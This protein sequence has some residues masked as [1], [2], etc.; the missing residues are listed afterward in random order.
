[1]SKEHQDVI[2][3][4][5]GLGGL[6]CATI[7][8]REGR[9]VLLLEK[10]NQL[11]GNLQTFSRDKCIFDTGVHYI[12]SLGK[13]QN[14]HRYFTYLG[15]M[16]A[17]KIEQMDP[18]AFDHISFDDDPKTYF[19]SQ[20]AE[21]F[22]TELTKQFPKEAENI[23]KFYNLMEACCQ[24]FP[25]YYINKS[26]G[27]EEMIPEAGQPVDQV[28]ASI[29]SNPSLQVVLAG[30]NMLYAGEAAQTPFY[31]HALS[32][33]SYITSA[34][35]CVGGGSQIA[36]QLAR[37]IR[38]HG[39]KI[40]KYQEITQLEIQDKKVVSALNRDGKRYTANTFISNINPK[41]LLSL[42]EKP[43]IR[44]ASIKR[45]REARD[46]I[47][48]FSVFIVLKAKTVPYLNHNIYHYKNK[49][50]VWN[51]VAYQE[52]NW[53]GSY[54]LSMTP[55]PKNNTWAQSITA[56]TYMRFDEVEKWANSVSTVSTPEPRDP[57][58]KAF[59]DRKTEILLAAI[60]KKFPDIRQ[61]IQAI[62]TAT[63]L[64][65]RDYIGNM[66]GD[67]YGFTKTPGEMFKNMLPVKT[68][69]T[70]LYQTGQHI[71]MHGIVGVTTSA[72]LT[73]AELLG[74]DYLTD[75]ILAAYS[76]EET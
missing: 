31:V 43:P 61:H 16:E 76:P 57:E 68:K 28:I 73:C 33:N 35:R 30:T 44:K 74:M 40:I 19:Y 69:L 20:T 58:Y 23:Q 18:I 5:S 4:G 63:P 55:D 1:M 64:T 59:K 62:Y 13:G 52:E 3:I 32:V 11:G 56:F 26:N 50:Q 67:M 34:W 51:A 48:S 60:E 24:S 37:Q 49:N 8:A 46:T 7:L 22:V 45:I 12:G 10:N 47:S 27:Y 42:M 71:S 2:I 36:K 29:T 25:L 9:K 39:G 17:L 21:K 72:I 41:R 6:I 38:Q 75:Q 65:Y 70:N 66:T 53:P 54:M 14:L 15:I